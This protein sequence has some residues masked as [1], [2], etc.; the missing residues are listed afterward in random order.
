MKSKT[1][2]FVTAITALVIGTLAIALTACSGKSNQ[3]TSQSATTT[4]PSSSAPAASQGGNN[5]GG[6]STEWPDD[7]VGNLVSKPNL[8]YKVKRY[9]VGE[10]RKILAV[11]FP[12]AT[13]EQIQSYLKTIHQ[14]VSAK[15]PDASRD[16]RWDNEDVWGESLSFKN[17]TGMY[18]MVSLKWYA[19]DDAELMIEWVLK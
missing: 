10:G 7:E 6:T 12:G 3:P 14:D 4:P 16:S 11:E 15:Y 13:K 9:L 2:L 8:D 17:E 18:T 19:E 1:K 5:N